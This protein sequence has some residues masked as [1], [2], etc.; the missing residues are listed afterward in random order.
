MLVVSG[1]PKKTVKAAT[2]ELLITFKMQNY[3]HGA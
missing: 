2:M 3:E 1:V